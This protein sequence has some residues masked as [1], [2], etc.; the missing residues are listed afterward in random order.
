MSPIAFDHINFL[1]RDAFILA[2]ITSGLRP[3]HDL[4]TLGLPPPRRVDIPTGK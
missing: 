3:F 2:D 4:D 1:G